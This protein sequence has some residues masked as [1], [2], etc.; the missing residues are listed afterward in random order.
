M[1][2]ILFFGVVATI[3]SGC[4]T[5]YK[6]VKSEAAHATVVFE[7]GYSK[8]LGY[9]K[10][11]GQGY[12][13]YPGGDCTNPTNAAQFTWV[14]GDTKRRRVEVNQPLIFLAALTDYSPTTVGA[15]PGQ[16][17]ENCSILGEFQPKNGATYRIK[18]SGVGTNC[19]LEVTDFETSTPIQ[20]FKAKAPDFTGLKC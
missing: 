10:A 1:K 6:E 9:G 4:T 14:T 13:I 3:C 2:K 17:Q 8:G 15:N 20:N 16:L 7:K 18:L 5:S 19:K 11:S 12:Y